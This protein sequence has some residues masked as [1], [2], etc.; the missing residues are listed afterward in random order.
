MNIY[1]I[2]E[3]LKIFLTQAHLLFCGPYYPYA[4]Q[5][6]EQVN[7]TGLKDILNCVMDEGLICNRY[8]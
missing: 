8:S 6:K 5:L 4:R 3:N 2:S 1:K 7:E